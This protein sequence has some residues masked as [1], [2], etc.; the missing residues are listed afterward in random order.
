MNWVLWAIFGMIS[1]TITRLVTKI[2]LYNFKT[3]F[4]TLCQFIIASVCTL[5]FNGIV[6]NEIYFG[7]II[8]GIATGFT[9]YF[10][11]KSY[12]YITNPGLPYIVYRIEMILSTILSYFIFK[13]VHISKKIIIYMVVMMGSLSYL[14]LNTKKTQEEKLP[15]EK[16]SEEIEQFKSNEII[17]LWIKYAL[18]S[19]FSCTIMVLTTKSV[20]MKSSNMKTHTSIQ[21][22]FAALTILFVHKVY[23][24]DEI[25]KYNIS[26]TKFQDTIK[27]LLVGFGYFGFIFGLNKSIKISPNPGYTKGIIAGSTIL[28]PFISQFIF[29]NAILSIKQ[30]LS[31]IIATI[32]IV[33]VA[34]CSH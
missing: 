12:N 32:C 1:V 13:H 25:K 22:I 3:S 14:V 21:I 31:I 17:P 23:A 24:V 6:F 30:W 26:N 20:L 5:L 7:T 2:L 19:A 4:V 16:S 27:L 28:V 10:L 9:T 15:E 11:N 33:Q 29:N 18:L 8:S 34:T